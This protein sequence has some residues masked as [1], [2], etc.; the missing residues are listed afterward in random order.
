MCPPL[1]PSLMT[2]VQI[3]WRT[4]GGAAREV[5]TLLILTTWEA[6][7]LMY[8]AAT[9]ALVAYSMTTTIVR[10]P[11]VMEDTG[12]ALPHLTIASGEKALIWTIMAVMRSPVI[13][14]KMTMMN[15]EVEVCIT[16]VAEVGVVAITPTTAVDTVVV[17]LSAATVTK[18]VDVDLMEVLSLSGA[19]A[20]VVEWVAALITE[21]VVV[22]AAAS[23]ACEEVTEAAVEVVVVCHEL[24]AAVVILVEH[25][26]TTAVV[27]LYKDP[28]IRSNNALLCY[29]SHNKT[30]I[31]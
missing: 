8:G 3:T 28:I 25:T 7:G 4:T 27:T 24:V 16:A 15:E 9:L 29:Q 20:A 18:M 2:G 22:A 12:M 21:V 6:T 13:G 23:E 11:V 10:C 14:E 31:D 26:E 1:P 30:T 19:V 17:V 5:G